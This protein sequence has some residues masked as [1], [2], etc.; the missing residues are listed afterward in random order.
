MG[1]ASCA[2][3]DDIRAPRK[4]PLSGIC[5][6]CEHREPSV[7]L[8]AVLESHFPDSFNRLGEPFL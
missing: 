7:L 5:A 1:E 6:L 4:D 2:H 3:D 8:L